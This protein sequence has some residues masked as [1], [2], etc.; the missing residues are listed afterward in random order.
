MIYIFRGCKEAASLPCKLCD[1]LVKLISDV[2]HWVD[3]SLLATTCYEMNQSCNTFLDRPLSSMVLITTL[4]SCGQAYN[5][6]MSLNEPSLASCVMEDGAL[7]DITLWLYMQLAF[8]ALNV[9]FAMY[10]QKQVFEQIII[11]H[12]LPLPGDPALKIEGKKVQEA[13]KHVFLH[14]VGV[15]LYFFLSL[16]SFAW[17][18]AGSTWIMG[19]VGCNPGGYS[20]WAYYLGECYFW[21]ACIY[22]LVWYKCSCCAGSVEFRGGDYIPGAQPVA[23]E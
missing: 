2:C 12:Q 17:S 5:C 15:L 7:V 18:W 1:A 19:G 6:A 11:G 4:L 20:G 13:F 23:E 10:F 22:S 9:V 16:A 14:D 3:C 21:I 8:A